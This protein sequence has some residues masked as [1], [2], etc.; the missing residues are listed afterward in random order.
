MKPMHECQS[1]DGGRTIKS[2][3]QLMYKKWKSARSSS[4]TSLTRNNFILRPKIVT[5]RTR[6]Q[7]ID[8]T[9]LCCCCYCCCCDDPGSGARPGGGNGNYA[10]GQTYVTQPQPQARPAYNPPSYPT[11]TYGGGKT[12]HTNPG[13]YY[14]GH[15]QYNPSTDPSQLV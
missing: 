12:Q 6:G 5:I 8:Y 14:P 2:S 13:P 3:I 10:G 9:I 15:P 1:R 7:H 4:Q 11:Q